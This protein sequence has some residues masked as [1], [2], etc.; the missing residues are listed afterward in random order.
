MECKLCEHKLLEYLYGELGEADASAM[1]KHLE[2]S[3][4]CRE[5]AETFA[6]VLETVAGAE[7][8]EDPP[9]SLHTRIMGHAEEAGSKRRS[10]WAW[11]FRPA[12]TTVV[13]G[14]ITAGVYYTT[15]R[16][17]PTSYRQERIVSEETPLAKSK[18]RRTL[19]PSTI[20]VDSPKK[21][22]KS[23]SFRARALESYGLI[24]QEEAEPE[25]REALEKGTSPM[26]ARPDA[27]EEPERAENFA[28]AAELKRHVGPG[29]RHGEIGLDRGG[30]EGGLVNRLRFLSGQLGASGTEALA[31]LRIRRAAGDLLEPEGLP[32]RFVEVVQLKSRHVI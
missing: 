20:E 23:Q 12:V 25:P 15:I 18:Q 32:G 28:V 10:P 22:A 7:D 21:E 13:I 19:S 6:S 24:E 3:E 17:K 4:D 14:A 27:L 31:P 1:E 9:P 11:V 5:A 16:V 2:E 30:A 26:L 29:G 8:D